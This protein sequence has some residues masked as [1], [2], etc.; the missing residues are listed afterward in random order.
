MNKLLLFS[1]CCAMS[2]AAVSSVEC[3]VVDFG[4]ASD[5]HRLSTKAFQ[6]AID[7][8]YRSGGGVVTVP[9][10]DFKIGTIVLK[11]NVTLSLAKGAT[12]WASTNIQ[13]YR[14]PLDGAIKPVLIYANGAQRVAITGEGT[15]HGRARR[16][17]KPLEEVDPYMADY[18][19]LARN[20]GVE[21][22][23]YYARSPNISLV[24]FVNC[25]FIRIHRTSFIESSFWSIHLLD[26][27]HVVID[28]VHVFTSL[29]SGVNADGIDINCSQNVRITNS[30]VST[31]DDAIVL[32][33]WHPCETK[34]VVVES[35]VVSSSSSAL[36][37]GTESNGTF[38]NIKFANCRVDDSNRGLSIMVHNSGSVDSVVFEN[39]RVSCV[40]RHFN[41][42]GNGDPI[43][44]E[45][46]GKKENIGGAVTNVWFRNI[47]ATGSGT[48]R[49]Y[50][51]DPAILRGVYFENVTLN[52]VAENRPDMRATWALEFENA[53]A[54]LLKNLTI[55]WAGTTRQQT[56]RGLLRMDH[57]HEVDGDGLRFDW[58]SSGAPHPVVHLNNCAEMKIQNIEAARDGHAIL[59]VT[60]DTT[61]SIALQPALNFEVRTTPEVKPTELNV[62]Q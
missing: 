44:V 6:N 22:K 41:W 43:F 32:K 62:I 57:C 31:G 16:V 46:K 52:L 34:N 49:L 36:K 27:N 21:M 45:V 54:L 59:L 61:K 48:S 50:A 5:T 29:E 8:C 35:C 39:I 9:Q 15:I 24:N 11:S 40:R 20:S 26:C 14:L 23:R 13:H 18:T 7:S 28:S 17:Y 60:G 56:W 25:R 2:Y 37:L 4:A 55:N 42:W 19:E 3:S 1:L 53:N 12:L 58:S 38:R 47:T 10:G 51:A 30:T 33:S